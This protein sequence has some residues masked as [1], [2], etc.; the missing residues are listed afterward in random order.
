M[1]D[2]LQEI[3]DRIDAAR[4]SLAQAERDGD[5]YLASIRLGEIESLQRL[6]QENTGEL[7]VMLDDVAPACS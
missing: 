5:E 6:E 1:G 4:E 2:F 7:P 3:Q